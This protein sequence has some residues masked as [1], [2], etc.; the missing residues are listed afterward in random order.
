MKP[1]RDEVVISTKFGISFS[2]Y[3]HGDIIPDARP[4][5]IHQSVEGSLK[6]LQTE[7]IDLYFQHRIDPKVEPE[8][9]AEVMGELIKEGKIRHWGVSVAPEDYIRRAHK[10]TPIS[11]VQDRYS[12][13]ARG[14]EKLFP[15]LEEL[16]IGRPSTYAPTIS[17]II[18][19][20]YVAKEGRNLYLTELGEVVNHIMKQAF[21]S[22]VESDFTANVESLLDKVEEGVVNW[23]TVVSNFYPDLEAAVEKAEKE[24]EQVKIEDEVTDVICEQCGRNMVV[25]YGPHG[26]FLACPGFPDCR[27]TKPYLEKIGVPCPICGKDVVIRKTKKG[28]RYYGCE[29]NPECE[30]MSWQKPSTKK[31]PRCGAYMLEKGNKL[32]CSDEQCGYVENIENTKEN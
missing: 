29:D 9:V 32:V 19:R 15:T 23:K 22:I 24:L 13:M 4:E 3:T 6:R 2:K 28:R 25:K 17:T 27:N 30:F 1:F 11:A 18:A 14:I 5:K 16:G 20:R 8:V 21:P 7:T 31:C 10:V 26:K 12:M